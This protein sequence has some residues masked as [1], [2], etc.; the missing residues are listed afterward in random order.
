MDSTRPRAPMPRLRAIDRAAEAAM[1]VLG[2]AFVVGDSDPWLELAY[3]LGWDVL[4]LVYLVVGCVVVKRWPFGGESA[5]GYGLSLLSTVAPSVVGM[6]AAA[7][8]I[9]QEEDGA[10]GAATNAAGVAAIVLAWMLLHV[11]FARLYAALYTHSSGLEFPEGE[12]PS[13]V[14]FLYFAFTIAVSFAVSDVVV[15]GTQMRWHV[16]VH[17]TASFFYNAAVLALAIGIVTGA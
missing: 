9:L 2:L 14:E 3:L 7:T 16:M 13:R 15:T 1:V 12:R 17:G 11:G 5:R 10:L 4:A 6:T 8:V